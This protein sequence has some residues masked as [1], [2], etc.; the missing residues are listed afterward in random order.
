MIKVSDYPLITFLLSFFLMSLSAWLGKSFSKRWRTLAADVHEDIGVIQAAT[1]TLLGLI[2]G[3][4]FSMALGRYDQRKNLEEEEA[5][6]IG[7]EYVR[8]ELL[9]AADAAKVKA[10]LLNYLDQ[11][12][13]FYITRDEQECP[14]I[15][16]R[17]AQLQT[18][19]WS[20]VRAPAVAQPEPV[21]ALAV[22][23]MNDVLNS[24]GYSQAAWWNRIPRAAWSLM[25][26][27][28]IFCNVMIG[29]GAKN[30]RTHP[31]FFLILPFV[32]SVAFLLIADLDSPRKGLIHVI[33][34]N[35]LS[36]AESLRAP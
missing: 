5:N 18:E 1:L 36:L 34:Q 8:A 9:P 11:R 29:F 19:L 28:A 30:D 31:V 6:A 2:I 24:Q 12:V 27:I 25:A 15:N 22:A 17:T 23:G 10:L 16:A 26:A 32:L 20:A 35:L 14:Q 33:P 3:F 13:L 4:T 21:I 7:T